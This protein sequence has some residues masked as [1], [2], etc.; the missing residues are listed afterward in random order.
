[1]DRMM[2]IES[3][4][5]SVFIAAGTWG[6][7][8]AALIGLAA[9]RYFE[10]RAQRYPDSAGW[11]RPRFF[12]RTPLL[13]ASA[14]CWPAAIAFVLAWALRIAPGGRWIVVLAAWPAAAAVLLALDARSPW[15][16]LRS[17]FGAAARGPFQQR[18][19]ALGKA[20]DADPQL[21]GRLQPPRP[22]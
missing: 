21:D 4:A 8:R 16:R 5:L 13:S 19:A 11:P 20:F 22:A 14:V 1:M 9:T 15:A 12:G 6:A 3:V 17:V 18:D 7:V 2:L 10:M